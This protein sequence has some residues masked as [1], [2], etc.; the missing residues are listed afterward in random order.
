MTTETINT[1]VLLRP[2]KPLAGFVAMIR[3]D[4]ESVLARD[5]AARSRLE[6]L[7]SGC[8]ASITGCGIEI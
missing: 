2:I 5:P 1:P 7:L 8:T 3:R 6:V 4:V